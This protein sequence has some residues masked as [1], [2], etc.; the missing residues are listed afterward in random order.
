MDLKKLT[1]G[2]QIISGAGILLV[3][4]LLFF[5]WHKVEL[6]FGFGDVTRRATQSPNGFYGV[7]ALLV[8]IAVVAVVLVRKLTTANLPDLPVAW[9]LAIFI[10]TIVIE[11]LLLLKLLVETDFLG[12]GA[13]VNLIL[14][15]AMIYGGFLV[16]QAGDTDTAA[17]GAGPAT[18][19]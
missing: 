13:W 15:A 11:A 4:G 1:L 8:A 3:I 10:A 17:P 19:F 2:E 6:G 5:P 18:P 14:G 12:W 16:N 9:A 7:L